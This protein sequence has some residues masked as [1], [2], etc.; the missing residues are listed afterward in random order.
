MPAPNPNQPPRDKLREQ[1][2]PPVT[3]ADRRR[4]ARKIKGL[5]RQTGVLET[6]KV[7]EILRLLRDSRTDLETRMQTLG[8][9]TFGRSMAEEIKAA[10]ER[11]IREFELASRNLAT[12]ASE[13]FGSLA[14]D[15]MDQLVEIQGRRTPLVD[16]PRSTIE[17]ANTRT[18]DLI[19]SL[20]SRHIGAASDII[21]RAV[22]RGGTIFEVT[23]ELS[24]QFG[25]SAS[26]METIARTE[27]LGIASQTQAHEIAELAK[28]D[29]TV[30]KQWVTVVDGRQRDAHDEAH[31]QIVRHDE[32]FIVG[33]EALDFPRD[34]AG[35][36]WNIINC[37]CHMVPIYPEDDGGILVTESELPPVVMPLEG[38]AA[39]VARDLRRAL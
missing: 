39:E 34:P 19:R 18:A 38:I 36:P 21:N 27:L 30:Q 22:L 7:N 31:L 13:E 3:P 23:Q 15:F 25:K 28:T 16:L 1:D 26:Q 10:L 12:N 24:R 8:S 11:R 37:R 29:A 35:S 17:N 5:I 20:G 6:K 14:R 32:P 2:R 9:G 33:G 4:F